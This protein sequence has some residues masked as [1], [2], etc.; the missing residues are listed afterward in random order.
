MRTLNPPSAL[1]TALAMLSLT[2]GNSSAQPTATVPVAC[3]TYPVTSGAR[4]S[5][6]VPLFDLPIRTGFASTVTSNTIGVTD[7]NWTPNQF[8]AAGTAY[9]AAIRTG[10]QAGR[11]LLVVGNTAN[12][13]TLDVED[14]PLDAS[15]FALSAGTDSIELF[16]GDTL[17][18]LFGTS[19]NASGILASGVKG[20]TTT[21]N[22]DNIQLYEGSGFVT[23]FFNTTVGAWVRN[24]GGTTNRNGLILY[25]DDGM[26]ITRRGPTGSLTFSGRVPS[27]RLLTKFSGGTTSVTAI[28]F[29]ADTT[30]G[31]LNFGAPGTWVT[32]SSASVADTVSVWSGSSWIVYY[33]NLSNQWVRSNGNGG[34]QGGLVIRSGTSIRVVKR[35][36]ATGS[37]AYFSQALPYGL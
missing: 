20:G 5:F 10:P 11:T 8:A 37:A 9:F 24:G 3:M 33:K 34:N 18:S 28:R 27:T 29:P 21:Q 23:Y 36:S 19:A 25:P 6:G 14:T 12:T 2:A 26:L 32:G 16:Q 35:G 7:V 1:L 31:G 22:A 4:S 30:L 13:L 15:G 17:G